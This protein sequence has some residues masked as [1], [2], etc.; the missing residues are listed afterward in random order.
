[1]PIKI[2]LDKASLHLTPRTKQLWSNSKMQ[3]HFLPKYSP[4]LTPVELIF[5]AVKNKIR[6]MKHWTIDD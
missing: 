6:R 1:M 4:H 3:M 2:M 5:G